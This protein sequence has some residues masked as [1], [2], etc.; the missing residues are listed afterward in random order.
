MN[1]KVRFKKTSDGWLDTR[2][3]LEWSKT[4]GEA[5]WND[6]QSL[7]PKGWRLPT[8]DELFS[9]VDHTR[10][11]P[12]TRL[13]NTQ[14]SYYWSA[15]TYQINPT[16]AWLVYFLDGDVLADSKTSTNYV[17]AVRAGS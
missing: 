10:G 15:T 8:I 7:I 3:G 14:S 6:A 16:Y 2:T 4:L 12:A 17:R 11:R 1:N 13:P 9:V 5:S